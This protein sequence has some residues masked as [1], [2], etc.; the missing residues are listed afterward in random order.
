ML[1]CK[2]RGAEMSKA[3]ATSIFALRFLP[4]AGRKRNRSQTIRLAEKIGPLC[5]VCLKHCKD[6]RQ[7]ARHGLRPEYPP[8]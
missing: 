4:V 1:K 6:L 8:A 7:R 5:L 3:A 2:S